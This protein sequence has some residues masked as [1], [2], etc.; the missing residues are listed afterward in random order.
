MNQPL[1]QAPRPAAAAPSDELAEPARRPWWRR[2]TF[3]G[4]VLALLA[5][6]AALYAWQAQRQAARAPGY[7]TAPVKRGSV[8]L[9][10]TA[11]GTLQPTRAVNIGSELSGTVARVLVDVNDQ[12]HAGQ[13]LVELDTAKLRDQIVRSRA[14]LA[15]ARAA[16]AQNQ[17][18]LAEARSALGRD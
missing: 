6:G 12:V 3:W 10:V 18:S 15:A 17:A 4:G 14:A 11:N 5:I 7:V 13:V 1:A 8:T 2:A 16:L 9:S